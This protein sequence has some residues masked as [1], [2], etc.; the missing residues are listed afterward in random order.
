MNPVLLAAD[1]MIVTS[2]IVLLRTQDLA[3]PYTSGEES[4][5]TVRVGFDRMI[6]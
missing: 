2:P 1:V 6:A 5:M 3:R 4:V